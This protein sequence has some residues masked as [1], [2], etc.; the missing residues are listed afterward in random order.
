MWTISVVLSSPFDTF[1]LLVRITRVIFR[2]IEDNHSWIKGGSVSD[3]L[4]VKIGCAHF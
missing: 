3:Y 2:T 1:P 4:A